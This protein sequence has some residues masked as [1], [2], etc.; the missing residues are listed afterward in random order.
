MSELTD[1]ITTQESSLTNVTTRE[2]GYRLRQFY[3][4]AP[5]SSDDE[6]IDRPTNE[7]QSMLVTMLDT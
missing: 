3:A 1:K 4:F 7:L 6:L 2:C 5:I